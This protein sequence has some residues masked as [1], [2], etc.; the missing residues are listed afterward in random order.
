MMV[1][2]VWWKSQNFP[3]LSRNSESLEELWRLMPPLK[4]WNK[5]A[6]WHFVQTHLTG[7]FDLCKT[8]TVTRKRGL[9]PDLKRVFLDLTQEGIQGELQS[10]VRREFIESSYIPL[11]SRAFS[12]SKQR[13]SLSLS[14]SYIEVLSIKIQLSCDYM[15][16]S[17]QHGKII[18]L[19]IQRKLSL[20]F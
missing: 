10:E 17:R 9:D 13:N 15:R 19:L 14:F 5:Q 16:A 20:R 11:Q 4:S 6:L 18:I 1:G 8:H 3:F 2:E 12:E 7:H